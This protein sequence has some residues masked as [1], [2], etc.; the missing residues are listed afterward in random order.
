MSFT[1]CTSGAIVA[2]AGEYADTSVTT[3]GGLLA[4]FS[5]EA[6]ATIN[7]TARYDFTAN[8]VSVSANT[9][10]FLGRIAAALA[11]MDIINYNIS[12]FPLS[13]QAETM[14]D[15]LNEQVAKGLAMIKDKNLQD[16]MT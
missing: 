13:R 11:A 10:V 3:S 7:C 6:E 4:Q 1:F 8:W 9:K 15:V 12:S 14:L 16:F 2:K 5:D